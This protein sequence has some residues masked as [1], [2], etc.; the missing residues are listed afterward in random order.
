MDGLL[1]LGFPFAFIGTLVGWII[2]VKRSFKQNTF[3]GFA[4]IVFWPST[5]FVLIKN[6]GVKDKDIKVPFFTTAICI[7]LIFYVPFITNHAR[8]QIKAGQSVN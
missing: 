2:L 6:W 3:F 7:I 8:G 1:F 4:A 5:V